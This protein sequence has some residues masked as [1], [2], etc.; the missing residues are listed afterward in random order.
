[1][2]MKKQCG[3]T[4]VRIKIRKT[5]RN[6]IVLY[7]AAAK[8]T[9]FSFFPTE[10]NDVALKH[11]EM[12]LNQLVHGVQDTIVLGAIEGCLKALLDASNVSI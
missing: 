2:K 5:I 11:V 12:S 3:S 1:M 7:K 4:I 8:T 9:V 6:P 10:I